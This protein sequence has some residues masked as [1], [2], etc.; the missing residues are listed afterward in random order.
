M[1]NQFSLKSMYAFLA[2][3][4][5]DYTECDNFDGIFTELFIYRDFWTDGKVNSAEALNEFNAEPNDDTSIINGCFGAIKLVKSYEK[6]AFG[7]VSTDLSDPEAVALAIAR[8]R[9]EEAF[10]N[11]LSEAELDR[12][13]E[14]N[15]ANLSK[16]TKIVNSLCD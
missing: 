11:V 7:Q 3:S 15:D 6:S 9:G 13:D 16:F 4:I 14:V 5:E 12:D 8:I 10:N 1:D 2:D